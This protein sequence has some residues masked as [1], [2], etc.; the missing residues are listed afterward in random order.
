[1]RG[2]S[3]GVSYKLRDKTPYAGEDGILLLRNGNFVMWQF[4]SF[5]VDGSVKLTIPHSKSRKEAEVVLYVVSLMQDVP[6]RA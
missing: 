6:C 3:P 2:A 4:T 5:V 1:M